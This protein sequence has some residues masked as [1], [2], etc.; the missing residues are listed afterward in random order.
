[1]TFKTASEAVAFLREYLAEREKELEGVTD[2]AWRS[3]RDGYMQL[4]AVDDIWIGT[5]YGRCNVAN[6]AFAASSR[7]TVPAL[8]SAV[9]AAVE[10][11]DAGIDCDPDG[12]E[13]RAYE[14]ASDRAISALANALAGE[15]E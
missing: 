10:N 12:P 3:E 8:L 11:W 6:S 4:K 1:M 13:A 5:F 14:R 2:G 15:G 7:Q 9:R